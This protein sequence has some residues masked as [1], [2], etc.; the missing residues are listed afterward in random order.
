MMKSECCN[1]IC[2]L[3]PQ[4]CWK[5]VLKNRGKRVQLSLREALS[6]VSQGF[7][8]LGREVVMRF[9]P[10]KLCILAF[11][12]TSLS[13]LAWDEKSGD[14]ETGQAGS[15]RFTVPLI[16]VSF[17][18]PAEWQGSLT[19][20][21][22]LLLLRSEGTPGFLYVIWEE[23]SS[24]E[25]MKKYLYQFLPAGGGVILFPAGVPV[26][27]ENR[28]TARYISGDDEQRYSGEAV[29]VVSESGK[30][31]A[32]FAVGPTE[33]EDSLRHVLEELLRTLEFGPQATDSRD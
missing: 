26:T 17:D 12:L 30:A 22:D 8:Y 28:I 2:F 3:N 24:I 31:A 6:Q 18:I 19:P 5:N 4:W 1:R 23:H 27:E 32:F 14:P 13:G 21:G 20:A 25:Q 33:Y 11:L 10:L 9:T 7:P 16:E 29:A 15:T